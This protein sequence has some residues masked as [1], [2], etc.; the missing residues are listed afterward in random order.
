M[1][2]IIIPKHIKKALEDTDYV[3]V[4]DWLK[5]HNIKASSATHLTSN[6]TYKFKVWNQQNVC[7]R[8][9]ISI[10]PELVFI[11]T[12]KNTILELSDV[13]SIIIES[14]WDKALNVLDTFTKMKHRRL[15]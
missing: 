11:M 12:D 7:G 2:E 4:V 9:F 1:K 15:R 3:V 8:I 10:A 5:F 13:Y 14:W 6:H